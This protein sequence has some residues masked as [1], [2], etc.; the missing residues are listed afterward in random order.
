MAV[1]R[2]QVELQMTSG[3][4]ADTAVNTWHADDIGGQGAVADLATDIG[5]FYGD[6][7]S[8]YPDSVAQNNHVIKVYE[9]ADA[10]PRIPVLET[11][12][13]FPTV[14]NG[15]PLPHQVA[16]CLSA[17]GVR[18]SGTNQAS[19]RGRLYLGPLDSGRV[20]SEGR[21]GAG[22]ATL[23]QGAAQDLGTALTA[24]SWDWVIWS[25]TL[26]EAAIVTNGW[27]DDTFD[28]QR[29][30]QRTPLSRTTFTI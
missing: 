27:I 3:V 28:I 23:L 11:T 13:N 4:P 7:V 16:I 24:D 6:I 18:I 29:R 12:F 10:E 30:R 22:T 26:S 8:I 25:P 21:V 20:D 9:L 15:D 14:P 17:Q 2:A 19:R 5:A 1:F